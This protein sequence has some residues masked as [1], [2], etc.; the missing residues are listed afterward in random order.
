MEELCGYIFKSDSP[1]CGMT[2]VRVYGHGGMPART[3]RGLFAE[4]LIVPVTLV[5]HYVRRFKISYL[6]GQIYLSPHPKELALRN[7]V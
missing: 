2:R 6:A 3:G 1:S 7:H 5:R 4:A